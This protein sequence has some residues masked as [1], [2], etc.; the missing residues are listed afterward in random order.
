MLKPTKFDAYFLAR[1]SRKREIEVLASRQHVV[2]SVGI[3]KTVN[4]LKNAS[5][6]Q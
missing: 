6:T 1:N 4:G 3:P 2:A 5:W